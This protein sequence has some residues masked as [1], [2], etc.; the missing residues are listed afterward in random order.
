MLARVV[1]ISVPRHDLELGT[2]PVEASVAHFSPVVDPVSLSLPF[3]TSGRVFP[4]LPKWEHKFTNY[5]CT[6]SL[7][8]P[9]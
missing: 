7:G 1:G 3:S 6:I 8:L 4:A 5:N 9:P 2:G